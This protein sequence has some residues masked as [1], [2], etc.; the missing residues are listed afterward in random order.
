[1]KKILV[2]SAIISL[3]VTAMAQERDWANHNY[4]AAKNAALEKVPTVVF[5][6]NSITD[7]WDDSHPEFFTDNNF[8]CRGISGQV[9]GQMLCR[10][11]ADVVDLHPKKLVI[12]GGV[13]DLAGNM[14][15]TQ[16]KYIIENVASMV[17]VAKQNGIKPY[18]CSV[19][20]CD[21]IPWNKNIIGIAGQ[22]QSLNKA[23]EKC[24]K[25]HKVPFVDYYSVMTTET[26][27]LKPELTYDGVHPT[28]QGYDVMEPIILKAL[29]K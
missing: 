21:T 26:G 8:A 5:M 15:P 27:G 12:L 2:L 29:K 18:I 14:G 28:R 4:Y 3:G 20:P 6:G 25:D 19:L 16:E 1:M 10:M 17:E 11:H 24:A 23:L 13:N 22:V 7:G 9:T